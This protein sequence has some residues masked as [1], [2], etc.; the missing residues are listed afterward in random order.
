V[1]KTNRDHCPSG[2]R[3]SGHRIAD[4]TSCQVRGNDGGSLRAKANKE[5]RLFV[6]ACI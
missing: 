3:C 5:S 4:V 1:I 6:G 2:F